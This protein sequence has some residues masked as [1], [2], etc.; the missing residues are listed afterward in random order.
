MIKYEEMPFDTMLPLMLRYDDD[1]T[2]TELMFPRKLNG[3]VVKYSE[4]G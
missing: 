1:P 3:F 2:V 4:F